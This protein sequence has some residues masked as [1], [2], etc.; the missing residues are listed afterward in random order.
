MSTDNEEKE[1]LWFVWEKTTRGGLAV[2]YQPA[3]YRGMPKTGMGSGADTSRFVFRKK[4][5]GDDI[6]KEFITLINQYPCPP[7]PV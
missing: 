5:E 2:Q 3:L 4:I 1:E 6:G 7:K